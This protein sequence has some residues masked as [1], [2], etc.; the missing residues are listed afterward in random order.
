MTIDIINLQIIIWQEKNMSKIITFDELED[1]Y[2]FLRLMDA[3][4]GWNPSPEYITKRRKD[5][6]YKY[7]FGFCLMKGKTLAGFVGVMDIPVK[8]ID[9]K[10]EKIGGIHCVATYPI[11]SR[12]G[13]AKELFDI[14]H[15]HFQKLGY[16]F[17][18][19]FTSKS[20]VAHSLYEKL[21]YQDFTPTYKIFR[22]YKIF[23]KKK[24]Q[25]A[26]KKNKKIKVNHELIQ[27]IY[28][29]AMRNRTGFAARNK[30]W[31][32]AIAQVKGIDP[33]KIFVERDGYAFVDTDP[34][35]SYIMEFIAENPNA[36]LKILDKI[37]RI[38]NPVLIDAFVGDKKLIKIYKEQGF[39]FRKSTYFSFMYKLF[40][41]VSFEQV[42]GD[43]FYLSALDTF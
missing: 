16:R 3:S 23:P 24:K 30:N 40:S 29:R 21:G 32:K 42:F 27:E 43:N 39:A 20:L 2:Q 7:P 17:S 33:S 8:T 14:V 34:D 1:Y 28:N 18:F 31:S 9:G 6:R 41:D 36:Y 25:V 35:V 5:K 19:L 15:N 11:F 4:F 26:K 38:H 22:A 37:K 13:I 10:I 12:Q